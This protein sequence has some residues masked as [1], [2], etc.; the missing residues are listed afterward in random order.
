M[1]EDINLIAFMS[2]FLYEKKLT[3]L[4]QPLFNSYFVKLL[5]KGFCQAKWVESDI[6]WKFG[7]FEVGH[8]ERIY[9]KLSHAF[10]FFL[11]PT[12]HNF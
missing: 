3:F 2:G 4:S 12:A 11:G 5:K 10:D 9:I 6:H 7:E 1:L 8:F